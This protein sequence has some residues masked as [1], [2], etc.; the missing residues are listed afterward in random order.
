MNENETV[1][2]IVFDRVA[3]TIKDGSLQ[4]IKKLI[5]DKVCTINTFILILCRSVITDISVRN[6]ILKLIVD[7]YENIDE[8]LQFAIDIANKEKTFI[9]R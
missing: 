5:N 6:N 2:N 8:N 1:T 3:T 9:F 4:D 7:E